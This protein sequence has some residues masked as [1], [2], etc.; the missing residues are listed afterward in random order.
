[1]RPSSRA[2]GSAHANAWVYADNALR[3]GEQGID[4]NLGDFRMIGDDLAQLHQHIDDAID[5][6]R[7]PIAVTFQQSGDA[8]TLDLRSRERCV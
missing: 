3:V 4:V 6:R 7:R 1:M 8:G 2:F 5:V